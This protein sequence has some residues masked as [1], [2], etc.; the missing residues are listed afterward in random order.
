MIVKYS[1][2]FLDTLKKEYQ[3]YRSINVTADWRALYIDYYSLVIA[4]EGRAR[5][6]PSVGTRAPSSLDGQ[7][8]LNEIVFDHELRPNGFVPRNDEERRAVSLPHL[9][10]I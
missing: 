10:L 7:T 8:Y 2:A 1:P 3:G 4:S 9:I 6:S 5:Q